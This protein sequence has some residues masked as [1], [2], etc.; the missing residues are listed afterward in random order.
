MRDLG[1]QE[2]RKR[3]PASCGMW[4]L[5]LAASRPMKQSC[6]QEAEFAAAFLPGVPGGQFNERQ[7]Q[8]VLP[9]SCHKQY[10]TPRLLA[11][12]LLLALSRKPAKRTNSHTVDTTGTGGAMDTPP[13]PLDHEAAECPKPQRVPVCSMH[14]CSACAS[15][16]L[17]APVD[18]PG[19]PKP[20][21]SEALCDQMDLWMALDHCHLLPPVDQVRTS[22]TSHGTS[23]TAAME[24]NIRS[25]GLHGCT[26]RRTRTSST[27]QISPVYVIN[28]T[29]RHE[30]CAALITCTRVAVTNV[31]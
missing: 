26:L 18:S 16:G 19:A 3:C 21:T 27:C 14:D 4:L 31:Q 11:L 12:T 15:D 2:T 29:I 10:Y 7:N 20:H 30:I 8:W 6:I 23:S 22:I 28:S 25:T 17:K 24:R 5:V 9:M 13:L 1:F